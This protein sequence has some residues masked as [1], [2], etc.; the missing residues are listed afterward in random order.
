M[1]GEWASSMDEYLSDAQ[2]HMQADSIW[3]LVH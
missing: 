1:G 2:D 3:S